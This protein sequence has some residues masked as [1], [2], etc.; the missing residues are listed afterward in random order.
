MTYCCFLLPVPSRTRNSKIRVALSRQRRHVFGPCFLVDQ[1]RR[2]EESERLRRLP[3]AQWFLHL[4]E[5]RQAILPK[6]LRRELAE[7]DRSSVAGEFP[8]KL[9]KPR[10]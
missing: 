6:H 2:V 5:K 8:N 3:D 9:R 4:Q 7:G 10:P 1:P